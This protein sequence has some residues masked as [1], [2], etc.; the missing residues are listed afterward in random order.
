MQRVLDFHSV[1][2]SFVHTVFDMHCNHSL[3]IV[4]NTVI[5]VY[6]MFCSVFKKLMIFY[7]KKMGIIII[8]EWVEVIRHAGGVTD[9]V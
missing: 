5:S 4:L 8:A 6:C 7:Y 9:I 1:D 2:Y 3:E